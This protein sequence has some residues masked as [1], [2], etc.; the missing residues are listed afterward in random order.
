MLGADNAPGHYGFPG[1]VWHAEVR[2]EKFLRL[3]DQDGKF[4][5]IPQEY[6]TVQPADDP[7]G[8]GHIAIGDSKENARPY[9]GKFEIII[10]NKRLVAINVVKMEEYLLGV[11]PAEMPPIWHIEA[12]KAQ[13]V[14]ARS[15][16]YYN[17]GRFDYRKFDLAD[18][19]I[20]QAY[21]GVYAE[22]EATTNA[23]VDTEGEVLTYKGNLANALY[24]STCGGNTAS[25]ADIFG[26]GPPD[27]FVIWSKERGNIGIVAEVYNPKGD[28]PY[29]TGTDDESPW[30]YDYCKDSLFYQWQRTYTMDQLRAALGNSIHTDPGKQLS[31][32]TITSADPSGWV[33]YVFIS[34]ETDHTARASEF[35]LAL[36]KY[37]ENNA[38]P[39]ANFEIKYSGGSYIFSGKGFGHGVGMCQWGAKGRADDGVGYVNILIHYYPGCEITEI[40]FAG[41]MSF[42]RDEDFFFMGERK[43]KSDEIIGLGKDYIPPEQLE[44]EEG[45]GASGGDMNDYAAGE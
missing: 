10:E 19:V 24:H 21:A 1:Q 33:Q 43:R 30:D 34:G 26:K 18:T 25:A 15:Y 22:M 13:S 29:L 23:V 41:G 31:S 5:D 16:A 35:R 14:A 38:L 3:V 2:D 45:E 44:P 37:L 17:L 9:R 40:P 12:L 42:F 4:Y 36:N 11:V 8:S 39:S 28:V 20:S 7:S 27:K 6:I 32:I